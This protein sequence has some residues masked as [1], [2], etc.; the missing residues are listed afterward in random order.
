MLTYLIRL[1][2]NLELHQMRCT[3]NQ[4]SVPNGWQSISTPVELPRG[5]SSSS[6]LATVQTIVGLLVAEG[7]NVKPW[8]F[9]P[10]RDRLAWIT[11]N[12][13]EPIRRHMEKEDPRWER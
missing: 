4:P 7:L 1:A 3:H 12:G 10:G 13:S 5:G 2:L 9:Q 8:F 11:L 6:P